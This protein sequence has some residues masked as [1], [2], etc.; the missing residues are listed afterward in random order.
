MWPRYLTSLLTAS[1]IAIPACAST[2]QVPEQDSIPQIRTQS[3]TAQT[4]PAVSV[5]T[6]SFSRD[7]RFLRWK[8]DFINRATNKGYDKDTVSRL[9]L[10]AEINELAIDRNK[11]QPEFSKPIWSYVDGAASTDRLNK[12]RGKLSEQSRTFDKIETRYQVP[13]HILTAIW[14]L[15]SAYGGIMGNHEIISALSTF[16]F[17]GR[18]QKFGEQQL[19][20][21]SD[22]L[23]RNDVRSDQLIGC[24]LYTSPSPRD[25]G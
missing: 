10:P 24:L 2:A 8:T 5:D 9:I 21:V 3:S 14:G 4:V 20:A 18:R 7:Q 1:C 17:E 15:E 12:G 6:K 11:K 25:R 19:F 13:R 16:A 23:K 22:M